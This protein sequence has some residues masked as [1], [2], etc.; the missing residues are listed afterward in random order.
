MYFAADEENFL[1]L[2]HT[3]F[4]T[5]YDVKLLLS[6][7]QPEGVYKGGLQRLGEELN[8]T[9]VGNQHQAGSDSLLTSSVFF[10]LRDAPGASGLKGKLDEGEGLIYGLGSNHMAQLLQQGAPTTA[11]TTQ[12]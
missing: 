2:L 6:L 4:P 3:Y 1:N 12:S 10:K 9:R 7:G 8:C 11:T 5:F